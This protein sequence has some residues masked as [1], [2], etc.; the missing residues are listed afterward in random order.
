MID[1][2]FDRLGFV[3]KTKA[4]EAAKALIGYYGNLSVLGTTGEWSYQKLVDSYKSWVYVCVD[5]IAKSVAMMP[6]HLYVYRKAGRKICDPSFKSELRMAKSKGELKYFMKSADVEREQIL[7][8]PFLTLINRPNPIMT[9]FMLWY[10]TM[11]RLEVGGS[12]GWYLPTNGLRLPGQVWPLPLTKTAQL[13]PTVT[14][15]MEIIDWKYRDGAVTE[16]FAPIEI[17]FHKYPHPAGPF[18]GMSPLMAQAYPYDIDQYLMIQQKAL[19]ENMAVTGHNLTT[20]QKL[21]PDQVKEIREYLDTEFAGA[22]R[23]GKSMVLHSGLKSDKMGMTTREAML[24]QVSK[25][26]RQKMITSYDLSEGK[27]GLVEDANR[28]NMEALNISFVTECLKPKGMLLEENIETFLLPR[29]DDGLTCDFD[30]PDI[31]DREMRLK[32]RESNLTTL[33][34]SINEER[35]RD[36]LEEVPWGRVPFVPFQM[37]PWGSEPPRPAEEEGEETEEEPKS[38][39]KK[40]DQAFWT[41]EKKAQHWRMFV[42]RSERYEPLFASPMRA[43]LRKTEREVLSRLETEGKKIFE[44]F[45]GWSRKRVAEY[46]K[47]DARPRTINIDK[48]KDSAA[49]RDLFRPYFMIVLQTEGSERMRELRNMKISIEFN[50]ND[51][52]ARKWLGSRLRR[53]SDEVAGTTFDEIDRI[54]KAGFEE[55]EPLTTIAE[56]LREKFESWDRYRAPL[57]ARTE[58]LSA[59][60]EADLLSVGQAGLEN[61]LDKHW[62]S[63]R[64]D[65][66]RDTHLEA[67]KRYSDD[68]IAI[69][70]DFEVGADRMQ[71]PGNGS[72][73]EENINCRC[74]IFYTE[75]EE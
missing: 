19:F 49:T 47:T 7:D 54:L 2:I 60:N 31:E 57:I 36:G 56:T 12:C 43:H 8:H 25:F 28:A 16:T 38:F 73:P 20:E 71:C 13:K 24:E 72:K 41:E 10:E 22:L 11:V 3:S 18:F 48:A 63:A 74:T 62:L 40:L 6:L 4:D 34:S 69:D 14:S 21:T 55:G 15:R 46:L 67:D 51:P 30:L 61:R 58:A 50:L 68:G 39:D 75:K 33:Y 37:M 27:I 44:S 29:Y 65:A 42:R 53:F 26:A 17:L 9:R 59:V 66:C 45:A 5:K 52:R 64:D 35:A 23:A 1:S 32:E 70:E